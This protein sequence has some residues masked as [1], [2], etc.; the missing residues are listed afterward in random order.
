MGMHGVQHVS[1]L[2]RFFERTS[3]WQ[4]G[5]VRLPDVPDLAVFFLESG[6]DVLNSYGG[7]ASFLEF[8]ECGRPCSRFV[9]GLRDRGLESLDWRREA[10]PTCVFC[11]QKIALRRAQVPFEWK[12]EMMGKLVDEWIRSKCLRKEL[13]C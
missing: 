13:S 4:D 7:D 2:D 1:D 3:G 10:F 9:V 11:W 12:S 5:I 6:G 8:F